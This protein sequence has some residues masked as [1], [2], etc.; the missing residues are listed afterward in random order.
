MKKLMK[1]MGMALAMLDGAYANVGVF[2]GSGQTPIVEKTD[3]VQMV[4]EEVLMT[5]RKAKGP[6]TGSCRNFDPMDYRCTFKLRNLKDEAVELQVGFPLDI[7]TYRMKGVHAED[8]GK[9]VESFNFSAYS[10]NEKFKVRFVPQDKEKKF[11]KLF[12]WTMKFA[13]HEERTLFVSYTMEGYLGLYYTLSADMQKGDVDDLCKIDGGLLVGLFETGIGE[14]HMYVTGT[15]SCWAGDIQKATFKYFPQDFEAYLAKRGALDETEE[16][17]KQ[18]QEEK[19]KRGKEARNSS[20]GVRNLLKPEC[21]LVRC[22]HPSPDKW[23]RK[24]DGA[25]RFHYELT[26]KPFRPSK[27]DSIILGYVAPPMPT[28]PDDVDI[29][30]DVVREFVKSNGGNEKQYLRDVKDVVLEFYGIKTG[31]MRIAPFIDKQC[32]KGQESPGQPS[33]ALRKRLEEKK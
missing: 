26:F 19:G 16:E 22:W 12:L 29:L 23:T 24:D 1:V 17:R 18:R 11:S 9:L 31:N 32:W 3:A 10:G 15:G 14:V 21:R 33:M 27:D 5:P 28:E 2:N 7:E 8:V 25:G 20:R 13:A 4:E 30:E 6:V